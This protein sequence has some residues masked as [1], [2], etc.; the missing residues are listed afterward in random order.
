[1]FVR[2]GLSLGIS[3]LLTAGPVAQDLLL[4]K[5]VHWHVLVWNYFNQFFFFSQKATFI[6]CQWHNLKSRHHCLVGWRL[7][8]ESTSLS[9]PSIRGTAV[10][11]EFP[12]WFLACQTRQFALTTF[13]FKSERQDWTVLDST[14][15]V[16]MQQG[17]TLFSHSKQGHGWQNLAELS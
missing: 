13:C 2:E 4:S 5:L 17:M 6:S 8:R 10:C 11:A 12:Q 7:L 16:I 14:G 1:M 9:L 15:F 3:V